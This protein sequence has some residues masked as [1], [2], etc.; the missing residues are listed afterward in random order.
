MLCFG[1]QYCVSRGRIV[2]WLS[3]LCFALVG[4]GTCVSVNKYL[5]QDYQRPKV[6]VNNLHTFPHRVVSS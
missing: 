2:F 6:F 5:W 3:V 4:H 1:Y